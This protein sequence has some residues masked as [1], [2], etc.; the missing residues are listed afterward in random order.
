MARRDSG[1]WYSTQ[2]TAW[3]LIALTN[4]LAESKEFETDYNFAV[5]LNG[6]K[7]AQGKA[8][9]DNL[10]E[11]TRL[12]VDFKDLL[13]DEN[14]ALV[15]S[16]G[17]GAGNLYYA[18]YL[19][20][21]L[22]VEE[23]QPL[24]RGVSLSREYFTLED[25]K[26]PIVEIKRGDLVRVRLTMVL[27]EAKRYLIIEDP[28]PAGLEALDASLATDTAVPSAYTAQDYKERGW[29]WWYFNHIERRDE[30]IVLS[31]DYLPA[32]TYVYSYLARASSAGTFN[33]IP[34]TASEFYFPDV[35]GRGAGSLFTV[36]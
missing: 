20:A 28:L 2:E 30:K 16:R 6:E 31:A 15:F 34:P 8:S 4:W 29:G 36:K 27:P 33:V 1:H 21:T 25:P 11:T 3:S 14:N 13:K 5:G 17:N 9:A 26:K 10:N 22:P 32:G 35:G 23:V 18:A 19:N 12:Q 7:L 24:D